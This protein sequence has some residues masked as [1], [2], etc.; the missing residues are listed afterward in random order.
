MTKCRDCKVNVYGLTWCWRCYVKDAGFQHQFK[1]SLRLPYCD[2]VRS[3][4]A[5]CGICH[6]APATLETAKPLVATAARGDVL[7]AR[8]STSHLGG[9]GS[10]VVSMDNAPGPDRGAIRVMYGGVEYVP[11][12][13]AQPDALRAQLEQHRLCMRRMLAQLA[14]LNPSQQSASDREETRSVLRQAMELLMPGRGGR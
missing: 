2:C 7:T 12:G 10:I 9:Y 3:P 11:I 1:A 4:D 5:N 13:S 14:A 8:G 6:P